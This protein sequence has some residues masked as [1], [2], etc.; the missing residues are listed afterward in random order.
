MIPS[1]FYGTCTKYLHDVRLN[2]L[3][4]L[5]DLAISFIERTVVY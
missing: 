5:G 1:I 4:I 3:F 2:F